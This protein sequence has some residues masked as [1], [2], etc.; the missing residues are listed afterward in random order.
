MN[1]P[2]LLEPGKGNWGKICRLSSRRRLRKT[3]TKKTKPILFWNLFLSN[4]V[5][6]V[7]RLFFKRYHL[8]ISD[9]IGIPENI[10]PKQENSPS[11]KSTNRNVFNLKNNN[12]QIFAALQTNIEDHK[13]AF[14]HPEI[15]V[16]CDPQFFVP[17]FVAAQYA[18]R[19]LDLPC[20]LL[21]F[22]SSFLNEENPLTKQICSPN[23]TFNSL[24]NQ[25]LAKHVE[26]LN[27]RMF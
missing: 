2:D 11:L 1:L 9:F 22:S 4:H 3:R 5:Q 12:K 14:R 7:R 21:P 25:A 20:N 16:L 19:P 17:Q 6:R 26:V 23:S 13:S 24:F 8:K 15:P 27:V 10:Q 18:Y